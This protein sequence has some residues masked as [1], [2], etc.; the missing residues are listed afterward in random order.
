MKLARRGAGESP[1][2]HVNKERTKRVRGARAG[3]LS[4]TVAL[5]APFLS[6]ARAGVLSSSAVRAAPFLSI[7]KA[8]V[9]SVTNA[10]PFLSIARAGV[11]SLTVALAA[12]VSVALSAETAEARYASIVIEAESG[13]VL[14]AVNADT[15][16]YPASLTK[17]MTLYMTFDALER[18]ELSL[19][20]K[21]KVSRRAAGMTPSKLGLGAGTSIAV[22]DAIYAL[23]TKSANDVAVVLAERLGGTEIE[24]AKMMTSRA[25]DLGM[26]STSFR[27][28]SGLPNRGQLSTAHDMARLSQALLYDHGAHYH[29]FATKSFRWGGRVYRSHNRLLDKL[30]GTDGLKTGYIRASGFNI[31]ASTERG[32]VRLI[33]VVFGGQTGALRDA[34]A[35][36]LTEAAFSRLRQESE[37]RAAAAAAD[38]EKASAALALVSEARAS[39][40]GAGSRDDV[41][42]VTET[43][44]SDGALV[45][46]PSSDESKTESVTAETA[47][48]TAPALAAPN[49][50]APNLASPNLAA[51]PNLG[52]GIQV[53]AFS[54]RERAEAALGLAL[55]GAGEDLRG[56]RIVL[57][58]VLRGEA[59]ILR[60][61]FL[62]LSRSD[63]IDVCNR[64]R[65]T[66]GL[67]CLVLRSSN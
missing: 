47:V 23:V 56:N 34:H 38:G 46:L 15:K 4:L 50:A 21:L 41:A 29:Y 3:V 22:E 36:R 44:D 31:A 10:A 13:R 54:T 26:K 55:S 61:Q 30:P 58:E 5:A 49:L 32:G 42:D 33:T 53:G 14:H 25:R 63:A 35:R 37:L 17:M 8:A 51:A 64:L 7:A 24:F 18:G 57:R 65:A 28:A 40:P 66:T 9:L 16:N 27:N 45:T 59:M 11:L 39:V 62:D 43:A 12:V 48:V 1:C 6:I 20:D 19:N 60:A 67:D 52:W 2:R